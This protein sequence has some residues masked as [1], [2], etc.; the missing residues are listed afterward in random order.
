MHEMPLTQ[1]LLN[2]ALKNAGG[3]RITDIYLEVGRM[4]VV[5]PESVEVF[6]DYLSQETLAEGATLHFDIKP[7]E[8]TCLD[9]GELQDLSEWLDERPHIVMQ[10]AFARACTCGSKNLRVTG[11]VKFGLVSIDVEADS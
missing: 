7:I 3:Q 1:S 2:L 11:G 5:V 6:F 9:C 10:K 8:M 4:S